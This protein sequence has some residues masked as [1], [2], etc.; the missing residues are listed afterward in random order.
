MKEVVSLCERLHDLWT[1]VFVVQIGG[2]IN[3]GV[4]SFSL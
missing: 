4:F 3:T 2:D 1:Y